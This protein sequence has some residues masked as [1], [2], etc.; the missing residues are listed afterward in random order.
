[1]LQLDRFDG[2]QLSSVSS[3]AGTAL[4][5]RPCSL[6]VSSDEMIVKEPR[7]ARTSHMASTGADQ[8][9]GFVSVPSPGETSHDSKDHPSKAGASNRPGHPHQVLRFSRKKKESQMPIPREF[10]LVDGV[11]PPKFQASLP[12]SADPCSLW[13][14]QDNEIILTKVKDRRPKAT[15][16]RPCPALP[17]LD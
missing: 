10:R 11:P 13:T 7:V 16:S 14:S 3:V 6:L 2:E 1:M 5:Y 12:R 9:S 4:P 15:A 17:A 8:R